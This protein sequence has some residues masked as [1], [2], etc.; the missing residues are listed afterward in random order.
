MDICKYVGCEYFRKMQ[1][2]GHQRCLMMKERRRKK[3]DQGKHDVMIQRHQRCLMMKER[4]RKKTGGNMIQWLCSCH[5]II[6]DVE[7]KYEI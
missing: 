5:L 3:T 1:E 7:C 4:R 2:Q 6:C